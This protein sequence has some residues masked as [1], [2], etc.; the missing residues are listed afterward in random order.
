MNETIP[1]IAGTT[2][3][4]H[5]SFHGGFDLIASFQPECAALG[6]RRYWM[7]IFYGELADFFVAEFVVEDDFHN[8]IGVN[9]R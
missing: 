9:P 6:I 7:S 5:A 2:E 4:R 1:S 3:I 8:P